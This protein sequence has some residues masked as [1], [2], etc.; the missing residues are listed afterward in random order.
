MWRSGLLPAI[1]LI[2]V[3][4]NHGEADTVQCTKDRHQC[5]FPFS[6]YGKTYTSCTRDGGYPSPWCAYE[7]TIQGEW[8]QWDYCEDTVSCIPEPNYTQYQLRKC[9][10]RNELFAG[11]VANRG[12]CK[13]KC[14]DNNHCVS[15]EWYDKSHPHLAYGPNYCQLSASCTLEL[16]SE[17]WLSDL[18]IKVED[19]DTCLDNMGN[20]CVGCM[21]QLGTCNGFSY[22]ECN[23]VFQLGATWCTV[24]TCNRHADGCSIPKV[25]ASLTNNVVDYTKLFKGGCINHDVC[26]SCGLHVG[27]NREV[28]DDIFFDDMKNNCEA[29]FNNSRIISVTDCFTRAEWYFTAVRSYGAS[30]FTGNANWCNTPCVG[31]ILSQEIQEEIRINGN[32]LP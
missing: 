10:G 31:R 21:D 14:D 19:S 23:N 8:Y 13:A 22:D 11:T 18:Y 30:Y 29:K 5:I 7:V 26:Y 4:T 20:Q 1:L 27:L 15:F 32:I 3:G 16:S 25:L 12:E 17:D 24:N 9:T 6:Y 28:C 2:S